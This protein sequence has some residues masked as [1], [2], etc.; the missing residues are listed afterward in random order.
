MTASCACHMPSVLGTT[1][2]HS[3]LD[4]HDEQYADRMRKLATA[5]AKLAEKL[6]RID[7]EME[8]LNARASHPLECVKPGLLVPIELC[9]AEVADDDRQPEL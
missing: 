4:A 5:R 1:A 2:V 3:S 7:R 9:N 6:G 8:K